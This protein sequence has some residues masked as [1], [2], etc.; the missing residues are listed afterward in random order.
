MHIVSNF[1]FNPST[2]RAFTVVRYI[3]SHLFVTLK[4]R[5]SLYFLVPLVYYLDNI[6]C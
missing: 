4:E 5:N 2:P 1:L 3:E 6:R